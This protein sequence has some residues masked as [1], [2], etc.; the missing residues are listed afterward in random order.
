MAV[1]SSAL[2]TVKVLLDAKA[3]VHATSNGKTP[4]QMASVN[5]CKA[6][7]VELLQASM[8]GMQLS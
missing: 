7:L 1:R 4:L 8:Q 6:E 3:S 5:R 2:L